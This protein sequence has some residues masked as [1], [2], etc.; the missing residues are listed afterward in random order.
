[1]FFTD[2]MGSYVDTIIKDLNFSN[3]SIQEGGTRTLPDGAIE[4]IPSWNDTVF[5]KDKANWELSKNCDIKIRGNIIITLDAICFYNIDLT[6]RIFI[7]GITD[8]PMNIISINYNI[9]NFTVNI[10]LENSRYYNRTVSF[11]T[12]GE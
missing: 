2:K 1:M 6:K 4:L 10:T 5:A 12:H 8:E 7:D 11:E 3:L 9:S